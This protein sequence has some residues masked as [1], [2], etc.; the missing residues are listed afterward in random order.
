LIQSCVLKTEKKRTNRATEQFTALKEKQ[1]GKKNGLLRTQ[2]G[3]ARNLDMAAE[4]KR[5]GAITG[6]RWE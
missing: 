1:K 3:R 4:T 2:K 6:E 5:A